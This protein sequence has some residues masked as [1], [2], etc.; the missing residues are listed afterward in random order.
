MAQI[1]KAKKFFGLELRLVKDRAQ[2]SHFDEMSKAYDVRVQTA[3]KTAAGLKESMLKKTLFDGKQG[4]SSNIN[5][6]ETAGKSNDELL[7]GTNKVQDMTFESLARTRN[8]VEASKEVGTSTLEE[9]ARQREQI[10][11]IDREVTAI[12]SKLN[13]AE[14]MVINFTR[15][16]DS[17]RLIQFCAAINIVIMVG[18]CLYVGIT[19]KKL[20]GGNGGGGGGGGGPT[21]TT[22]PSFRPTFAPV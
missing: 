3:S 16:I 2:R 19:G 17:D 13:R 21:N 15:R 1:K 20:S 14:K 6:Y 4:G 9:M 12:D 11:D 18:L 8:M 5:P 22:M 7:A 10:S